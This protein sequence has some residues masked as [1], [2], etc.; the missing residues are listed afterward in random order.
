MIT[1]I[2]IKGSLGY[3]LFQIYTLLNYCNTH[4]IQ[5]FFPLKNVDTTSPV[6][7]DNL[8]ELLKH[9]GTIND[10]SGKNVF[11]AVYKEPRFIHTDIPHVENRRALQLNGNFLSYKYFHPIGNE[12]TQ[13]LEIARKQQLVMK[14]YEVLTHNTVSLHFKNYNKQHPTN[15]S[16]LTKPTKLNINYYINSLKHIIMSQ[17]EDNFVVIYFSPPE[18]EESAFQMIKT[19]KQHPRLKNL[20]FIKVGKEIADWEQLLMMSCCKHNVISNS[21]FSWW[22]AYLNSNP[23]KIVT[24]PRKW[25]VNKKV[26]TKD[27]I[28]V[29]WSGLNFDLETI[30]EQTALAPESK[31]VNSVNHVVAESNQSTNNITL[32]TSATQHRASNYIVF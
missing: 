31:P 15:T 5:Y 1:S 23:N 26:P 8:L 3:Q 6:Y 28:P 19:L 14:K 32:E 30:I 24:Y 22:G 11:D 7:W 4:K 9:K 2:N 10:I 18:M 21:M 29:E 17:K 13:F 12:L 16:K 27:L 20:L 25:F